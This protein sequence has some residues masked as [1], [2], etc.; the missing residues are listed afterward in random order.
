MKRRSFVAAWVGGGVLAAAEVNPGAKIKPFGV[1]DL[2]GKPVAVNPAAG[3][4]VVT[5][6]STRCPVSN[7]Y[8]DRMISLYEAYGKKGV[9]FF[10]VNAN[11]TEPV[12]EVKEHI[13][14]AGYPFPVYKDGTAAE[15]LGAEFTPEAF[16]LD[17]AGKLV[18]HG[19]IDDSKN[20]AR[21]TNPALQKAIDATLAGKP[22]AEART[23]AFGCTI[24]RARRS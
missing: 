22:V 15:A 19:Y 24:K 10:F 20:T 13:G 4:T 3:V 21:V 23:R 2:S 17:K 6:I 1:V 8:N 7:G 5:F 18:Y 11:S 14:Q 16:V 12:S 9:Q